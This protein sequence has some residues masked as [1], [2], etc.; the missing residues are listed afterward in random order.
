MSL[1]KRFPDAATAAI[2]CGKEIVRLLRATIGANN[3]ATLAISGGTSPK[4]MFEWFAQ[5]SDFDWSKV[6]IFW[7]DERC[8]P[9]D[10]PRSNYKLAHDTWFVHSMTK[11]VLAANVH[12]VKTELPPEEAAKAYAEEIKPF[13]PYDVIHRGM[14]ADA[15]T[16]SLF[17]GDPLI[18]DATGLVGVAKRTITRITLLPSVLESAKHTVILAT[19]ADKAEP[20]ENIVRGPHEPMQYPAQIAALDPSTATWFIDD[21]AAAK[22]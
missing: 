12:R 1:L 2:A 18:N 19:G 15:H 8:V 5:Q 20:L 16:A 7:V 22:L 9:P 21:A 4:A 6:Q 13:L 3:T 11:D 10:D 17:P 14:G